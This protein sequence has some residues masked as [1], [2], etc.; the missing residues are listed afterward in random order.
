MPNQHAETQHAVVW[1]DHRQAKIFFLTRD[2]ADEMK[3][4]SSKHF[5]QAHK[6]AG[7]VDGSRTPVDQKFL[8][9]VVEALKPAH[10]WLFIGPGSAK[11][12]LAKHVK[13]HD[14]TL[15]DRLIGVEA[16]D[17]PTDGQIVAFARKYFK[18]ADRMIG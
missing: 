18:A 4:G 14:H 6:H 12:E 13:H 11:D 1:I 3:L 16:S 7:T 9:G 17:H 8:H 10:E 5:D 2:N 15:A